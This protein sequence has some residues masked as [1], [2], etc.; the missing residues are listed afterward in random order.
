MDRVQATMAVVEGYAEHVMD[1]VG[2]QALPHYEGLR[3]AMQRRRSSRSAPERLLQKLLGLDL[4]M[5]QY[6]DG[7]AFC[8]AVVATRDI[9]TL[10]RVWDLSRG[11]SATLRELGTT[12]PGS[13]ARTAGDP[14]ERRADRRGRSFVRVGA[15][16]LRPVTAAHVLLCLR[17][18]V[19]WLYSYWTLEVN[20]LMNDMPEEEYP[21]TWLPTRTPT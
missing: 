3:E 16:E 8:D 17:T 10:N 7:K 1:E 18:R 12:R 6:E 2:E 13:P 19:R 11:A 4:K 15:S 5:R 21:P 14:A 9:E 20:K